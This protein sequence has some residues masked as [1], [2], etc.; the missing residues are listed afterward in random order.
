MGSST[1][2]S[3]NPGCQSH[4]AMV[5]FPFGSHPRPLLSLTTALASLAPSSHFSFLCTDQFLASLP[6][7]LL[8]NISFV[9]IS[10]GLTDL[11]VPTDIVAMIGLFVKSFE[12]IL[13]EGL[14]AAELAAGCKVSCVMTDAFLSMASNVTGEMGVKWVPVW[15]GGPQALLAHL[16]T[17]LIREIVGVGDEALKTYGDK[18]IDFVPGL[19]QY[20]S[21]DLPEGIIVGDVQSSFSTMLHQMAHRLPN[22]TVIVLNTIQGLDS[23]VDSFFTQ[24]FTNYFPTGPFHLLNSTGPEPLTDPYDCLSWLDQHEP[25][26]VAYISVGTIVTIPPSEL[27]SLA[28]GLATSG[29]PFI[30]SLNEKT[31]SLLPPGFIDKIN[32]TGKGKIVPWAPQI[33]VLGHTA[34]GVF[35]SHCGYNSVMESIA[36]GVPI[37]CRPFFGDHMTMARAISHIW[38]IGIALDGMVFTEQG[39]VRALEVVL[40]GEEGRKMRDKVRELKDMVN[41]AVSQE[42]SS[43]DNL[44][45][46]V[47]IVCGC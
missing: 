10:D 1:T 7:P 35:V 41:I 11:T 44:K 42:G 37:L 25:S 31:Q 43:W 38:K 12:K 36:A 33:S 23:T 32:E 14:K 9:P 5:P 40:K 8:A 16:H 3:V 24:K 30:W 18:S 15:P 13:I 47:K 28:N 22:S 20:H 29:A 17:D 21:S 6:S 4:V 46:L 39:V 19:S 2:I 27:T 45:R 34:V 26:T